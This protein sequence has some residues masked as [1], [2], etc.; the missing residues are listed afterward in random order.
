MGRNQSNYRGTPTEPHVNNLLFDP[1]SEILQTCFLISADPGKTLDGAYVLNP[2]DRATVGYDPFW[3]ITPGSDKNE[4]RR[5]MKTV[6]ESIIPIKSNE[7]SDKFWKRMARSMLHGFMGYFYIYHNHQYLPQ[8]CRAIL[9]SGSLDNLLKQVI[10]EVPQSSFIYADLN[11]FCGMAAETL[12]SVFANVHDAILEFCADDDIVYC[13]EGNPRKVNPSTLLKHTIILGIPLDYLESYAPLIV[14]IYNQTIR[15]VLGL[16]EKKEDTGRAYIGLIL[17]ETVA[18][19]NAVGGEIAALGQA[20]RLL[21][22]KGVMIMLCV[23]SISG[24]KTIMDNAVVNDALSNIPW[25]IFLDCTTPEDQKMICDWGGKFNRRKTSYTKNGNS[26]NSENIHFD[27]DNLITPSQLM[28][29]GG[30][31][32]SILISS[33]AGYNRFKKVFTFKDKFYL[34]HMRY[35]AK[36]NK[37]IMERMKHS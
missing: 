28:T 17:D 27:D 13:L 8:I 19:L 33:K 25:K 24:L 23:Q 30:S 5:H 18:L 31:D 35:V 4:I 9:A 15:W 32:E 37:K 21:R 12:Y 3:C 26:N 36:H 10:S 16:P 2:L 7:K 29:L 11:V 20:L 1:K 22:S 34:K 6:C 14:L